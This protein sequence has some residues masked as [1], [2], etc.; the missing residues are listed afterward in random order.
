M[1]RYPKFDFDHKELSNCKLDTGSKLQD[2]IAAAFT[3]LED[4]LLAL[5]AAGVPMGQIKVEYHRYQPSDP[6][7]SGIDPLTISVW[8]IHIEGG[9]DE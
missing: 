9:I 1:G 6:L 4:T 2:R 3:D 8:S 5:L 7:V